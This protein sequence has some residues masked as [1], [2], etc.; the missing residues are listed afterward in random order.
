MESKHS[1]IKSLFSTF[2]NKN[3]VRSGEVNGITE[4]LVDTASTKSLFFNQLLWNG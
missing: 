3:F 1:L 2:R 4:V